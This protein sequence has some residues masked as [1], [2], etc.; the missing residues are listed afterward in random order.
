MSR[1]N[2]VRFYAIAVVLVLALVSY[3]SF[4]QPIRTEKPKEQAT[5]YSQVP[6][7]LAGPPPVAAKA[8]EGSA[9]A[10][11]RIPRF[12]KDWLWATLEGTSI[13]T[14]NQGP[15][16]FISTPLPGHE[17]NSVFAAHRATHGD[18]FIDFDT[19]QVG[20]QV[21]LAQSGAEWVYEITQAPVIIDVEESWILDTFAPGKWL[22]LVTCWPKY[23]SSKRM[24]IRAKLVS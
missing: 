14:I 10:Y 13:D 16:H 23:G 20:D 18:P 2:V 11:M 22:T 9:L 24:F 4:T 12:G 15:G 1:L 17:G 3:M 7:A 5:L 19:L 6:T 8:P 21:I